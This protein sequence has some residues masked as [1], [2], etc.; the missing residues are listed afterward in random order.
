MG[1]E[2]IYGRKSDLFCENSV[3][4]DSEQIVSEKINYHYYNRNNMKCTNR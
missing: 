3:F 4:L 2:I 1:N